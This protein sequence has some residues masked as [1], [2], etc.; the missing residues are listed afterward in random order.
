MAVE[1]DVAVA[2]AAHADGAL[3]VD[4]REPDEYE[5]GHVPNARLIPLPQL[6]SRATELPRQQ[7]LYL[8]CAA[9]GR[10]AAAADWLSRVG[11]DAVSVAGG[12]SAWQQAGYPVLTGTREGVA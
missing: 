1:V 9:G 4:V 10:S 6:G 8:I 12:T 2:A 11:F 5:A 3:V 7:K